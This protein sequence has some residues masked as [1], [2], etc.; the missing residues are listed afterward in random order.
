MITKKKRKYELGFTSFNVIL[1]NCQNMVKERNWKKMNDL[2]ACP[3]CLSLNTKGFVEH[4]VVEYYELDKTGKV[5]NQPSNL[6]GFTLPDKKFCCCLDCG[7]EEEEI[8][9]D[10]KDQ[11]IQIV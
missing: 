6:E 10:L 3:E 4:T 9:E 1:E 2:R 7:Y 8:E 11:K 5:S